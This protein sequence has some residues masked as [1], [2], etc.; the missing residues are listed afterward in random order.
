MRNSVSLFSAVHFK[1]SV[2]LLFEL[3]CIMK[4]NSA[5]ASI[6]NKDTNEKQEVANDIKKMVKS[7]NAKNNVKSKYNVKAASSK[8]KNT[9]KTSVDVKNENNLKSILTNYDKVK[10]NKCNVNKNKGKKNAH[11]VQNSLKQMRRPSS[12]TKNLKDRWNLC[13][14]LAWQWRIRKLNV[15]NAALKMQLLH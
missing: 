14:W 12:N 4:I 13:V 8:L 11:D 2:H 9:T 3:S 10:R 5:M 1:Q 7:K 6:A 15:L